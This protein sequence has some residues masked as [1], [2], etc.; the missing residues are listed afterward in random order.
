MN[1]L[2][3]P[4]LSFSGQLKYRDGNRRTSTPEQ[5]KAVIDHW[6]AKFSSPEQKANMRIDGDKIHIGNKEIKAL[7]GKTYDVVIITDKTDKVEYEM[8]NASTKMPSEVA[9]NLYRPLKELCKK[10]LELTQPPQKPELV[11]PKIA[12]PKTE[13]PDISAFLE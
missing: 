3:T 12:K 1:N 13:G 4:C 7:S 8:C 2:S 6:T 9:D 11:K 5:D 10:I